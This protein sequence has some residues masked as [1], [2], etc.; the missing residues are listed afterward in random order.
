MEHHI[1][2]VHAHDD[3]QK[4]TKSIRVINKY[5][6]SNNGYGKSHHGKKTKS[7]QKG[8]GASGKVYSFGKSQS[9]L[10]FTYVPKDDYHQREPSVLEQLARNH[11]HN[12]KPIRLSDTGSVSAQPKPSAYASPPEPNYPPNQVIIYL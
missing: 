4:N 5:Q 2:D 7:P 8:Y 1:N 9:T 3:H 12:G 6:K 11:V 10:P